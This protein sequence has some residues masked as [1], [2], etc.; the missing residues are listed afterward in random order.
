MSQTSYFVGVWTQVPGVVVIRSDQPVSDRCVV[1]GFVVWWKEGLMIMLN[2]SFAEMVFSY[3][4]VFLFVVVLFLVRFRSVPFLPVVYCP[5]VLHTFILVSALVLF[6][7][8]SEYLQ[9]FLG[10]PYTGILP[11]TSAIS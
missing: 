2:R 3:H 9:I 8:P 5:C 11:D 7:V 4:S 6:Q 1:V 10:I